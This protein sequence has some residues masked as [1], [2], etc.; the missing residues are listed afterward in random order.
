MIETSPETAEFAKA[1]AKAQSEFGEITKDGT[2]PHFQ[3]KYPTLAEIL[4]AARPALNKAGIYFSQGPTGEDAGRVSIVTRLEHGSGQFLQSTHRLPVS[5]NDAQ[6]VGS[7]ITYARRQAAASILGLAA[8]GEDDDGEGAVGRGAGRPPLPPKEPERSPLEKRAVHL[9]KTLNDVKL[10][11]DL[12]RAWKLAGDLIAEL[13]RDAPD[14]AA[15][16]EALHSE[17]HAALI[18]GAG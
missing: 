13:R 2:N 10:I 4:R 15:R 17:R 3:A 5:R 11:R 7:A 12:D 8:P 6:G 18:G 16:V 9:E 1:F 14:V